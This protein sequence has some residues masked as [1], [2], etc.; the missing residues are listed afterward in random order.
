MARTNDSRPFTFT[1]NSVTTGHHIY[2]DNWTPAL[3]ERIVCER[4]PENPHDRF[5]VCLRKEGH[6]VGH[7]PRSISKPCSYV[8]ATGGTIYATVSGKR[9]NAGDNGLVVPVVYHVKGP[10][11]HM[12]IAKTYIDS[13]LA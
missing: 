7:I 5:A 1:F 12:V 10:H 3:N 6:V 2:K 8:L 9:E 13:S 11:K 4:E